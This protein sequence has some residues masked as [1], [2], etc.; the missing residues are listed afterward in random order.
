MINRRELLWGA[1]AAG[2]VA[3]GEPTRRAPRPTDSPKGTGE[4]VKV[5]PD[6]HGMCLYRGHLYYCDAGI[7]SGGKSNESPSAG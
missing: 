5:D 1:V 6:P 2:V 7:G 3:N 4:V